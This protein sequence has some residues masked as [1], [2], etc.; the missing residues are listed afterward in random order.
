MKT[1]S[2]RARRPPWLAALTGRTC[3]ASDLVILVAVFSMGVLLAGHPHLRGLKDLLSLVIP[4]DSVLLALL[5]LGT[6][7][8]IFWSTGVYSHRRTRSAGDYLLRWI[9]ALNSST[10]VVGLVILVMRLPLELWRSVGLFWLASLLCMVL[11]R[12]VLLLLQR[13]PHPRMRRRRNLVI[14][15]SGLRA[16]KLYEEFCRSTAWNYHLL[17]FVDSAPQ[18]GFIARNQL[19]GG[20]DDLESILMRNVVDEVVIAL[21]M[22]SQHEA[23]GRAI[24]VCQ[25]LGVQSQYFTDYFGTSLTQ[26]PRLG[27]PGEP[28]RGAGHGAHRLPPQDESGL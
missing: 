17:G 8:I 20:I 4:M 6:W 18:Q 11:A 14:V 3:Q 22:R 23:A 21:P 13:F 16:Q 7:R 28:P 2:L 12:G 25:M 5:C 15:G 24:E 1:S 27:R 9:I 19:L 26:A 10:L